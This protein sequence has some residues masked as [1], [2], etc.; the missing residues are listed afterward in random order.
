MSKR[1][2]TVKLVSVEANLKRWLS[3]L[4]RAANMVGKLEKYKRRLVLE[5]A[6]EGRPVKVRKDK[7]LSE[8]IDIE[9]VQRQLDAAIATVTPQAIADVAAV[10]AHKE[11]EIPTFLRRSETEADVA[12]MR[13]ARKK[14]EAAERKK[15]PLT[16]KAAED[17]IKAPLK[18]RKG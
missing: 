2:P 16:G 12:K 14:A 11:E 5:K 6:V 4:T 18:K 7:P 17:Y 10:V 9:E 13:A 3:R 1:D 15:M 8:T